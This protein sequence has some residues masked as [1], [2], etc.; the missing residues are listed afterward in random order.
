MH[1]INKCTT[2][3]SSRHPHHPPPA[4]QL[5][6]FRLNPF[7]L[8]LPTS[9]LILFYL[10]TSSPLHIY[11]LIHF[12]NISHLP[13]SLSYFSH[14]DNLWRCPLQ[15]VV[16]CG[17]G[18]ARFDAHSFKRIFSSTSFP[19]LLID[20]RQQ[21]YLWEMWM[22]AYIIFTSPAFLKLYIAQSTLF[23]SYLVLTSFPLCTFSFINIQLEVSQISQA[24][25][26]THTHPHQQQQ[27]EQQQQ[28]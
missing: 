23:Y 7:T 24:A 19:L 10:L 26:T 22:D 27:Q 2:S 21:N 13:S 5:P 17:C 14:P 11:C 12:Q 18:F 16:Q 15:G 6:T 25:H 28:Q 9:S 20:I 3:T 8:L 4:S 1:R